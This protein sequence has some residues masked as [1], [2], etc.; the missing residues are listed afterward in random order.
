MISTTHFRILALSVFAVAT[1]FPVLSNARSTAVFDDII[2]NEGA[3]KRGPELKMT[4]VVVGKVLE[5]DCSRANAFD[6]QR[7]R[8][9]TEY[10][11]VG[12]EKF[13]TALR[14]LRDGE[15]LF[16]NQQYEVAAQRFQLAMELLEALT[17]D[18]ALHGLLVSTHIMW[19]EALVRR[20][21]TSRAREVL[22][23]L[24]GLS[25][26][27]TLATNDYPNAF[28]QMLD[29][30]RLARLEQSSRRLRIRSPRNSVQVSLNKQSLGMLPLEVNAIIPGIHVV[31]FET[32]T[33]G[34]D[35]SYKGRRAGRSR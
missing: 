6:G 31:R 30:V 11:Y 35:T 24:I 5:G 27:I 34:K 26:A 1:F 8:D 17:F 21:Q 33:M 10:R 12:G 28:L 22:G 4:S 29:E 3:A 32:G 2:V 25:P 18:G 14:L 13:Q 20:G 19:G 15:K 23:D 7:A 9:S 16:V